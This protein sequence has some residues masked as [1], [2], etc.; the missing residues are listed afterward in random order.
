MST[1][2]RI[3]N[4]ALGPVEVAESGTGPAVLSLHGTLGG[5]DQSMTL[6]RT[7]GVAG[8]RYIAVSRPGYLG[9]PLELGRSCQAQADLCAALLDALGIS[10]AGVIGLSGGGPTAL[11]LALRHP[12]RTWGLVLVSTCAGRTITPAPPLVFRLTSQLSRWSWLARKLKEMA[13]RNLGNGSPFLITDPGVCARILSEPETGQ[14]LAGFLLD[15]VDRMYQRVDGTYNDIEVMRTTDHA[16]ERIAAPTLVVHGTADQM[17]GYDDNA[18]TFEARIPGAEL[19]TI[20]GG[21]HGAVFTHRDRIRAAVGAFLHAHASS[22]A[23]AEPHQ[24]A[25]PAADREPPSPRH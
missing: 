6:V 21:E 13:A 20:E 5:W 3:V 19:L 7:I 25:P 16:L 11:Q 10:E 18:R 2:E 4:T 9:T 15:T 14:L 23:S 22:P 1:G 24:L 17:L 12:A 8:F